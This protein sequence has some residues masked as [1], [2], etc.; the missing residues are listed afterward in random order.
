MRHRGYGVPVNCRFEPGARCSAALR[1]GSAVA[2]PA[3][4]YPRPTTPALMFNRRAGPRPDIHRWSRLR[5]CGASQRTVSGLMRLGTA[6][7]RLASALGTAET[8]L[9]VGAT[10]KARGTSPYQR[11]VRPNV[12]VLSARRETGV[13][14]LVEPITAPCGLRAFNEVAEEPAGR[15]RACTVD[16]TS[17]FRS[18]LPSGA[19]WRSEGW[20]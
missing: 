4:R 2:A 11:K 9:A 10:R 8:R 1:I 15:Q 19:G 20:S 17:A 13:R 18:F 3:G 16:V 7:G 5:C 6:R 14:K 12:T